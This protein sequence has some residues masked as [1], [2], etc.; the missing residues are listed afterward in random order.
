MHELYTLTT[1]STYSSFYTI[2]YSEFA[3]ELTRQN[4]ENFVSI[5]T[6]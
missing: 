2:K 3:L 4:V 6:S 1:S 5:L